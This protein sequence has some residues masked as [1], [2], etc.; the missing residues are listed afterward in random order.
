MCLFFK[1]DVLGYLA[2]PCA[3]GGR[4]DVY[5][6]PV[7]R[8]AMASNG[9]FAERDSSNS[10]II[11]HNYFHDV[12]TWDIEMFARRLCDYQRTIDVNVDAQK[13]PV[14]L[15]CDDDQKDTVTNAYLQYVGNVPVIVANKS[16]NQNAITVFKTDAPFTADQIEELR[17]EVWNDA[18]SYLGV[19][20]VN[21]TKKERLITD[22]VQRNMGG[23]LASRNSPLEMRRQAAEQINEMFDLNVEVHYREDILAYQSGIIGGTEEKIREGELDGED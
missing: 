9:Y 18:M 1:D 19:S 2:L 8:R 23:V 21:V 3:I 6:I 12:P 10:V 16:M 22:E 5:N 17:V 20:N 7:M 15:L 4:L 14:L 13:T 11:Y